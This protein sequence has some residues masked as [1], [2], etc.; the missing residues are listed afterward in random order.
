MCDDTLDGQKGAILSTG[1]QL[2]LTLVPRCVVGRRLLPRDRHQRL[3]DSRATA[4]RALAGF[5]QSLSFEDE[6]ALLAACGFDLHVLAG[7]ASRA[8]SVFEILLDVTARQPELAGERRHSA[9]S[10]EHISQL[11]P[12]RH[13]TILWRQRLDAICSSGR[14]PALLQTGAMRSA[15]VS[16][17]TLNPARRRQLTA[18]RSPTELERV[19]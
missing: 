14:A 10:H 19:T 8:D 15:G 3:V 12:Q 17:S 16:G 1:I 4:R 2:L 18:R 11:P 6:P 9:R 5:G 13:S 7:G